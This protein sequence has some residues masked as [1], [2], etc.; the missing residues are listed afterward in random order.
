MLS[1]RWI[2][3][4]PAVIIPLVAIVLISF[5]Y[6][7]QN[8]KTCKGINVF[9]DDQ[10]ENY[11]VDENDVL[12]IVSNNRDDRLVG[13]SFSNIELRTLEQR[14]VKHE[15]V[16]RAEVYKDLTGHLNIKVYQMRPVARLISSQLNDRYLNSVGEVIPVS[17]KYTARVML[18]SGDFANRKLPEDLKTDDYGKE[19]MHLIDYIHDHTFWKAQVAQMDIDKKGNIKIYTQV[20]KQLVD[21]GQPENIEDKFRKL[22]IFYKKILPAK[23]W[24]FYE[25]VSVKFKDQIVCE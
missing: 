10:F 21:F 8:D 16:R 1:K 19:L 9:I 18:I 14:L 11:F 2:Q 23:G 17:S 20:S 7:K 25:S 13:E 15:F 12:N 5:S 24:N 3:K 22:E 4:A 6:E